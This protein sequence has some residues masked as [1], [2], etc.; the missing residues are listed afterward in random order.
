MPDIES[1]G[2]YAWLR[3]TKDPDVS[4]FPRLPE[5]DLSKKECTGLSGGFVA[6]NANMWGILSGRVEQGESPVQTLRR[7]AEEEWSFSISDNVISGGLP[8][9]PVT[10]HREDKTV[11]LQAIGHT[12]YLNVDQITRL[13]MYTPVF[14]VGNDALERWL[15]NEQ[16]FIRPLVYFAGKALLKEWMTS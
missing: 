6:L 7:E 14:Q 16:K 3:N 9:F 12:I 8:Q 11:H 10:Q 2:A 5:E 4:L 13:L 1:I 15:D